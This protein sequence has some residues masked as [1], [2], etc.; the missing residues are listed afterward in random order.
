MKIYDFL[1]IQNRDIL[2]MTSPKVKI[3]NL[4]RKLLKFY[5]QNIFEFLAS[6]SS[7]VTSCSTRLDPLTFLVELELESSSLESSFDRV[8]TESNSSSSRV[9]S[10]H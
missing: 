3:S 1:R 8:L 7:R 4:K 2:F 10:S 6:F 5:I 9:V